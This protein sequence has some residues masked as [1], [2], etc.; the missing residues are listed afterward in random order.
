MREGAAPR[1]L[2]ERS[3]PPH[4][5]DA[6]ARRRYVRGGRL[7]HR[8][9][10]GRGAPRRGAR[11]AR[12]RVDLLLRRR[13]AGEPPRRWLRPLAARRGRLRLHV[14]R[15]VRRRRP[16]SSGSTVSCSDG[17]TATRRATTST[18]RSR[19][20]S[21]RTR[22][23]HTA[24][25]GR[26]RCSRRS[27][28]I[29]R[30]L[31]VIDPRRT[32]NAELADFHLQVTAGH[33]RVVSGGAAQGAGRRGA[34]PTTRSST[35]TRRLPELVA[36]LAIVDVTAGARSSGVAAADTSAPSP[37]GSRRRTACRSSRTSAS[38]RRRTAR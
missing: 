22:G 21:A 14:E 30:C 32:E 38:S 33:R 17:R 20:S 5:S 4:E 2:P 29:R 31:I 34:R 15:V 10:R 37:A 36:A 27:R 23:S 7:G 16:A 6:P 8:D 19:C 18:P 1:P 3:A 9:R 11:R 13:R 26:A 12:R 25:L 35:S 24:S 28:R